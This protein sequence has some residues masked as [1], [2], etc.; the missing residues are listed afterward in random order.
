ME[1]HR[2]FNQNTVSASS[3][4]YVTLLL[5]FIAL[6]GEMEHA[7]PTTVQYAS[8][9][10]ATPHPGMIYFSTHDMELKALKLRCN[11]LSMSQDS[12]SK[13]LPDAGTLVIDIA[14]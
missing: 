12:L 1:K 13:K 2:C 4:F 7:V 10:L 9:I 3:D 6:C 11:S 5:L 14:C 8:R